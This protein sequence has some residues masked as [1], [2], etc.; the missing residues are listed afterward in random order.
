MKL[1]S[2]N[3][4][5][6]LIMVQVEI[7]TEGE[8]VMFLAMILSLLSLLH[9]AAMGWSCNA[10]SVL[11]TNLAQRGHMR[12]G[13]G[14]VGTSPPSKSS[15]SVLCSTGQQRWIGITLS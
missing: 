14:F 13:P 2:R 8:N 10:A 3:E 5:K 9:A 1:Y 15:Q 12:R 6:M 4:K 7:F 11:Y